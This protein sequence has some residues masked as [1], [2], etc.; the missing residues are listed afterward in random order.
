MSR[1]ALGV[2]VLFSVG[3]A[4]G[5]SACSSE[6]DPVDPGPSGSSS[7]ATSGG[8]TT[9]ATSSGATSS[10]A[11]SSGATSSGATSGGGD[12]GSGGAGTSSG[13]G[14]ESAG[15][16]GSGGAT[17]GG[18]AGCGKEATRPDP[19]TQQTLMVGGVT[20]YFLMYVPENYDPSK[21]LPLVFGI[22][23]LNMNNVWAAH[24]GSGFQLIQET[25][26]QA[27]LIYPQGLPANGRSTPPSTQS[28]WGDADSNWGGQP[29][30]ANRARLD[31]DLAFFDA[32]IEHAKSN[33]CVDTKRVFAVGFSQGG[34][35]TNTLGCERSSVFRGLAPVAG[36]GP[37]GSQPNCGD[38]SAAH[39]V[40]QTQG[41][42]DGTVTPALGQSTRDFWRARNGCEAE[43]MPSATFGNGC[44]EYQGCNEGLPLVYCTHPGGHSVPSGAGGRAWRFFQSL[45]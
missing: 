3:V 20:R 40:I 5:L 41:D 4:V 34:F 44:V 45:E 43:S 16:G 35:M 24:D 15:G 39:A 28:Q 26:D 14:G 27:L 1:S 21:P 13:T 31:A 37:N 32:M 23:G 8:S 30:N 22:H 6:S 2:S 29:P 12:G 9:G 25:D 17:P 7:A 10:G 38:A 19:R 11:T 36:W 18:S 33:Y 42:T